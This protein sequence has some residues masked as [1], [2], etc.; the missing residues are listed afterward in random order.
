[1]STTYLVFRSS[2]LIAAIYVAAIFSKTILMAAAVYSSSEITLNKIASSLLTTLYIIVVH[3]ELLKKGN[4]FNIVAMPFAF[5]S[6]AIGN[7]LTTYSLFYG[8]SFLGTISTVIQLISYLT[9]VAVTINMASIECF[10]MDS[11]VLF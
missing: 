9:A 8:I 7:V 2:D 1:M 4:V 6:W 10:C 3:D 11:F 5:L